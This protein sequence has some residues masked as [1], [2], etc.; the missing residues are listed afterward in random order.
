MR[1]GDLLDDI[2]NPAQ[3]WSSS[4]Q[5]A[6]L[7]QWTAAFWAAHPGHRILAPPSPD[8]HACFEM[9]DALV[10][11]ISSVPTDFL[12]TNRPYAIVNCTGR[13]AEEF[14]ETSATAR[15][16]FVLGS[17]VTSLE[18]GLDE[19]VRAAGPGPDPTAAAREQARH[20]LLGPRTADPAARF[21]EEL[22][23]ICGTGEDVD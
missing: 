9:A 22:D 4:A 10:A 12:A 11:D 6:E 13:S 5:D 8:L 20:Y 18:A 2:A 16:G 19:L 17:D 15:G 21:R 3:S 7:E 14:R 1:R 23:R